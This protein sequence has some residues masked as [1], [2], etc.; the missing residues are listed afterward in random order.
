MDSLSATGSLERAHGKHYLIEAGLLM[1]R[2]DYYRRLAAL[3]VGSSLCLFSATVISSDNSSASAQYTDA[4]VM[5]ARDLRSST[6][7]ASGFKWDNDPAMNVQINGSGQ[8][9]A[10]RPSFLWETT[11]TDSSD[12]YA[13]SNASTRSA[14]NGFKWGAKSSSDSNGFQWGTQASG[15]VDGFKWGIRSTAQEAGFKWGIRSNT[16]QAGFKWGIRAGAEQS[17]FKWGIRSNT[18]QTGFKW[19]I[20]STGEQSGFKWGIR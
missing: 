4:T 15:T 10:A 18:V 7:Q 19:G 16:S 5:V 9:A 20:R 13:A 17:G 14:V 1:I 2:N 11:S 12:A 8:T 3:A 6:T